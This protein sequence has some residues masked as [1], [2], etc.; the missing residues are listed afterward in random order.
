MLTR[1]KKLR[2]WFKGKPENL[3][4]L[5]DLVQIFEPRTSLHEAFE[6]LGALLATYVHSVG[7]GLYLYESSTEG[8][9]LRFTH[10]NADV[11]APHGELPPY[12]VELCGILPQELGMISI[13]L[14]SADSSDLCHALLQA[15]QAQ[16]I[17]SLLHLPIMAHGQPYG[18]IVLASKYA[19]QLP[20]EERH[21]FRIFSQH[22]SLATEKI[23]LTEGFEQEVASKVSQLQ[24]SEEKYRVLFEDASD[25]IMLVDFATQGFL[26]ANR[27]AEA[28]I[29]Y[30]KDELLTMTVSDLW[31]RQD[32]KRLS[33]NLLHT[34]AKQGAVTLRERQILRKDGHLL[35]IEI[36]ASAIEYQ[37]KQVALGIIRDISARKQI[38]LE[39]EVIDAIN[40]ALLSS[41]DFQN[42]YQTVSQKL[43]SFF[44]F[45]RMDILL[46]GSR[47]H[48]ARVFVSIQ[49]DTRSPILDEREFSLEGT[50]IEQVFHT[51]TPEII[52][53]ANSPSQR[54]MNT[55]LGHEF[56]TSLFFPLEYQE[57]I[58]GILHFGSYRSG[59]FSPQH[60]DFLQHIATQLAIALDNM[61]LFQTVNE[62]RAV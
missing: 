46:P 54:Q 21:L 28:L 33:R 18:F 2:P 20:D 6:Q 47:T 32:E 40:K 4:L 8:F 36:N 61:L 25:A 27:Q 44:A 19:H 34:L 53:Y 41:H 24:Q 16:G 26:D 3:H 56:H 52:T 30:S 1:R 45:E 22:L 43:R 59:G 51:G 13:P 10:G 5:T 50:P 12:E 37:G 58:I 38:E 23:L 62:E 42:V 29:G 17:L 55:F 9:A 49:S 11:F 57:R 39:K 31:L 48:T 60:F 15:C 35:W 14:A 7:S